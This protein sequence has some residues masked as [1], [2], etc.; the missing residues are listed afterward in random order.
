MDA[1]SRS[2]LVQLLIAKSAIEIVLVAGLAV[3]FFL[4]TFPHFQGWGEA[5]PRAIEGW[6]V[7]QQHPDQKVEVQLFID[8]RFISSGVADRSRP[9]IVIA[10]KAKDE[11]HGFSFELPALNQGYHVAR[12]YAVHSTHQGTRKTLQ[13]IGDPIPFDL[14]AEGKARWLRTKS[15]KTGSGS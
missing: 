4:I 14:D 10:G 3:G 5:T 9:D 11:W 7:S 1:G 15:S 2:K 8:D 12:A 13:L 6:V